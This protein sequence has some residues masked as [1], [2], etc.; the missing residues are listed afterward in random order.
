MKPVKLFHKTHEKM[1]LL[2][3]L[4]HY[5]RTNG[6]RRSGKSIG[7]TF[8][9]ILKKNTWRSIEIKMMEYKVCSCTIYLFIKCNKV[10]YIKLWDLAK[11]RLFGH[12]SIFS[13]VH[14]WDCPLFQYLRQGRIYLTY[15]NLGGTKWYFHPSIDLAS[16]ICILSDMEI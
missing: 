10:F 2:C 11:Q 3:M 1:W 4:R 13:W 5:S 9:T 8:M 7:M 16:K 14:I 12:S 6:F 15:S